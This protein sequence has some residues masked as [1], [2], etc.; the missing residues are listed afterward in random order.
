MK[1]KRTSNKYYT[2]S[3]STA[4]LY[5]KLNG[6]RFFTEKKMWKVYK[7]LSQKSSHYHLKT[8]VNGKYVSTETPYIVLTECFFDGDT[9]TVL[10]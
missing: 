5:V 3:F 9:F 10:L 6:F 2:I 1:L 7:N 4:A 8:N